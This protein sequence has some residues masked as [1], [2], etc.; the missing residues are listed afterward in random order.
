MKQF[1]DS[2]KDVF[3]YL[4]MKKVEQLLH[5][6]DSPKY[7]KRLYEK[8]EAKRYSIEKYSRY[9]VNQEAKSKELAAEEGELNDKLKLIIQK[10]KELQRNVCFF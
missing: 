2:I 8:F 4:R 7:L 9:Q 10:T 6:N 3:N 5:I 1:I